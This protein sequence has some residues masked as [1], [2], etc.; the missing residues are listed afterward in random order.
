MSKISKRDTTRAWFMSY[1]DFR[2][3]REV[4]SRC[5]RAFAMA[6]YNL[7]VTFMTARAL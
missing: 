5:P 3:P 6:S 2:I 7:F 1:V 4:E